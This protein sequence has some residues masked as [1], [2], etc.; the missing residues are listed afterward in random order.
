[1]R[2]DGFRDGSLGELKAWQGIVRD[3]ETDTWGFIEGGRWWKGRL[4]KGRWESSWAWE[5]SLIHQV[6]NDNDQHL[7]GAAQG[8]DEGCLGGIVCLR[9]LKGKLQ[10]SQSQQAVLHSHLNADSPAMGRHE[11]KA[12]G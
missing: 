6:N 11:P 2:V 7:R 3:Y 1:M 4:A 12:A 5:N 9:P 8:Y 10:D